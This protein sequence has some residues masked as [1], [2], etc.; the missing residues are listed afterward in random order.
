[1]QQNGLNATSTISLKTNITG[2]VVTTDSQVVT[3]QLAS[4]FTVSQD[5]SVTDDT[6]G[7]L[8]TYNPDA[9]IKI[10]ATSK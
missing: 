7:I 5:F 9:T 8:S 1:M 4:S 10:Y 3:C 2:Q 6:S